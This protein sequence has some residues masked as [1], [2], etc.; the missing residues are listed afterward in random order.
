METGLFADFAARRLLISFSGFHM[1]FWEKPCA[2][3]VMILDHGNRAMISDDDASDS[4]GGAYFHFYILLSFCC[5]G[6][7]GNR[8][9]G[10]RQGDVSEEDFK[11]GQIYGDDSQ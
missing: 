9:S 7:E 10:E 1:S 6:N 11:I 5:F 4:V 3:P 8:E 2:I